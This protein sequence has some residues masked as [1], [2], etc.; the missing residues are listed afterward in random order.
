MPS[1]T[2]TQHLL[3][4]LITAPEGAAALAEQD[5]RTAAGA[6]ELVAGDDRLSAL[7][8]VEIYANMYFYRLLDAVKE[9]YP[10]VLAMI[11][12]DEFHNL[13]TDYLLAHPPSHPSLRYAGQHLAG[14][15][16][17]HR[18]SQ[19]RPYLSDLARLE[20]AIL[21]SFDAPDSP[22]V[23]A[24]AMEAMEPRH[25]EEARFHATPSVQLLSFEWNADEI[26]RRARAGEPIEVPSRAPTWVRVWRRESSVYHR[27]VDGLELVCLR[28]FLAGDALAAVC[29]LAAERAGEERA[30]ALVVSL[31]RRWLDDGLFASVETERGQVVGC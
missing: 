18:L 29:E 31:L 27:P 4:R 8:R 11:G 9:D 15:L 12:D 13:I 26:R 17:G 22:L 1:L 28:R 30:A 16:A 3:R 2:E 14:F 5:P 23:S 6:A 7:E 20:W 10:A 25:W 21:D 24:A 19:Q